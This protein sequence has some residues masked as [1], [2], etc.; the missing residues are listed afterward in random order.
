MIELSKEHAE[1]IIKRM[2]DRIHVH[3]DDESAAVEFKEEMTALNNDLATLALGMANL[4][5]KEVESHQAWKT[6]AEENLS[7]NA[8][9]ANLTAYAAASAEYAQELEKTM[10]NWKENYI[11]TEK[12]SDTIQE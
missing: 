7:L 8:T 9:I 6:F 10:D 12:P 2:M 3:L 4:Y 1:K 5:K 11:F